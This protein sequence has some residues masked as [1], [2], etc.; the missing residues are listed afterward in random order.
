[1]HTIENQP[2][3]L[4]DLTII[5][6]QVFHH[7]LPVFGF[8]IGNFTYITDANFIAGKEIEK[9]KGTTVL[10]VNALQTEPHLSHLI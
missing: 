4:D 1:M 5:P 2:F 10:V 8:R 6:I 3:S 9:I 7:C